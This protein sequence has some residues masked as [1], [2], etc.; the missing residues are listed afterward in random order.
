M[1]RELMLDLAR[2]RVNEGPVALATIVNVRGHCPRKAGA[3]MLIWPD[4]RTRGTIGGGC[5]EAEVR[6]EA[7]EVLASGR[8]AFLVVDLWEDPALEESA[9]CGGKMEVFVEPVSGQGVSE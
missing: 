9:V 3:K 7:L 8:P 5:G 2:I 4:G 1:D 6:R